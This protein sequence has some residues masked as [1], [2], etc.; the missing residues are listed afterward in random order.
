MK[1][2][3]RR[4][5]AIAGLLLVLG[6]CARI[7]PPVDRPVGTAIALSN[8]QLDGITAGAGAIAAGAGEAEGMST[9][10]AVV[11]VT[12][13]GLGNG[14]NAVVSGQ[15]MSRASSP[16]AGSPATATSALFLSLTIP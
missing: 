8:L 15:V 13:V 11:V 7:A 6:G 14:R 5:A 10:S 3:P 4:A 16:R 9:R 12:A 1:P 2:L